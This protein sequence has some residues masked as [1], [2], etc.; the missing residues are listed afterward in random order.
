MSRIFTLL[1]ACALAFLFCMPGQAQDTPSL[2]D[3]ARQAQKEKEKDKSNKPAKVFT[4]EDLATGSDS[5]PSPLETGS[6]PARVGAQASAAPSPE[7]QI[8]RLSAILDL[9]DATDRA[10]LVKNV[11]KGNDRDFPG[12]AEW[13]QR[14]FEAKQAYVT[15][16]RALLAKINQIREGAEQLK[17]VQNPSDPRVKNLG[18]QM[19]QL[20]QSAVEIGASFQSVI[21]EGKDLAT[22]APTH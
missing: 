7:S 11:M 10:T 4:N 19:R 5:S 8:A 17:G 22:H 3:L 9:L 6:G 13:E 1:P 18:E 15:Q 2:G 14:L 16:G 20:V 21:M 12:R